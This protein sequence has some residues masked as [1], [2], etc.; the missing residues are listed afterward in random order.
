MQALILWSGTSFT[1]AVNLLRYI[2]SKM[3]DTFNQSRLPFDIYFFLLPKKS[4]EL[5]MLDYM[6]KRYHT[7]IS[8]MKRRTNKEKIQ[9]ITAVVALFILPQDDSGSYASS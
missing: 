3:R 2:I 8:G 4:K 7:G 6:I 5:V 9:I 1:R